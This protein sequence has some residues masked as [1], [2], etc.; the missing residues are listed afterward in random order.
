MDIRC[1]FSPP[2]TQPEEC[3]EA[4]HRT[5]EKCLCESLMVGIKRGMALAK[6]AKAAADLAALKAELAEVSAKADAAWEDDTPKGYGEYHAL[7]KKQDELLQAV[8]SLDVAE[9]VRIRIAMRDGE[10]W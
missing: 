6:K 9:Y 8:R 4:C 10:K 7:T 3:C 2:K 5:W 1:F